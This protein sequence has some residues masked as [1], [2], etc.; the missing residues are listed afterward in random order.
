MPAGSSAGWTRTGAIVPAAR[1]PPAN[2][3]E[4]IM[5]AADSGRIR[6]GRPQSISAPK[7]M[8]VIA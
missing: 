3:S 5:I 7:G 6:S 8:G 2:S 1:P 4:A